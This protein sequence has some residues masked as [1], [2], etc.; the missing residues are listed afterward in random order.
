MAII[1]Y[2]IR[3]LGL[4][5]CAVLLALAYYEGTPGI[6]RMPFVDQIPFVREFGVGRVELERRKAVAGMVTK[7]EN[8]ALAAVLALERARAASYEAMATEERKRASEALRAKEDGDAEIERLLIEASRTTG[9][10]YPSEQDKL[11]LEK[12]R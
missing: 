3:Q 1:L 9:L 8:A 2:T 11:W 10:T 4:T 6:N 5:G 12:S 7:A